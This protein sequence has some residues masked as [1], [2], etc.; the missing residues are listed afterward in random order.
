M[1]MTQQKDKNLVQ[2]Q[3]QCNVYFCI[4]I[5]RYRVFLKKVLHKREEKMKMTQ[6]KDKNLVRQLLL[7]GSLF[8]YLTR[9]RNPQWRRVT[10]V[11]KSRSV[12][13][14]S[15]QSV[16]LRKVSEKFQKSLVSFLTGF[17]R[18]SR[19]FQDRLRFQNAVHSLA[20]S[21]PTIMDLRELTFFSCYK[22]I[23]V[24]TNS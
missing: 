12:S 24:L 19:R 6:Q 15:V 7:T 8:G 4:K 22:W 11:R 17:R 23:S 2:I 20:Q 9:D 1:K 3:Q 16:S 13:V 10:V 18:P 14:A 5:I 21:S